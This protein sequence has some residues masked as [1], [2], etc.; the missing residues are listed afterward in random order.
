M[1]GLAH[2]VA[3]DEVRFGTLKL[4][5][6]YRNMERMLADALGA[7]EGIT[8]FYYHNALSYKYW[9]RIRVQNILASVE[10]VTSLSPD[11]IPLKSLSTPE[12]LSDFLHSTDKAVL[13]LEFCEWTPRLLANKSSETDL[14]RLSP[15]SL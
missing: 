1:K 5:V 3:S 8:V 11:E 12:E 14:G 4:M 6:L 2:V 15:S 7:T 10:Y 9:G 13:L